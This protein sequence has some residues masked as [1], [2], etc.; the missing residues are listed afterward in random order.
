MP[1]RKGY[2]RTYSRRRRSYARR[3]AGYPASQYGIRY[4]ARDATSYERYGPTKRLASP[5]QQQQRIADAYFGR[6]KYGL[7]RT[8]GSFAKKNNLAQRAFDM[9]VSKLEGAGMYSGQG[10]Y[11]GGAT[12]DLITGGDVSSIPQ[13]ASG[14][15]ETGTLTVQH[16]EYIRDVYGNP[17]GEDFLNQSLSLNPGLEA[18]FPWLSQVAQNFEE[19]EFDQL[20]FTYRSTIADVS[21]ANG[22]V[23]TVMAT[24]NYNANEPAFS[25]KSQMMGYAHTMS[26]KTTNALLHGVECDPNKLSG[27]S[28]KYVRSQGIDP[29]QDIKTYDHGKFQLAIS[30][31]P[32]SIA[33]NTIGELWVSYTVRL[34]KPKY[35]T[36]EGFGISKDIFRNVGGMSTGYDTTVLGLFNGA[37][38]K[39]V[40]NSIG[41]SV[42]SEELQTVITFPS[43]YA[44]N[45]EITFR[46]RSLNQSFDVS[47][48]PNPIGVT[49]AGNVALVSDI[50]AVYPSSTTVPG[51]GSHMSV[52]DND[53]VMCTVHV[54]VDIASNATDN[55]L[56]LLLSHTYP[57]VELNPN[58]SGCALEIQEY[59]ATFGTNTD[60]TPLYQ[61][62]MGNLVSF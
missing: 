5:A 47:V 3:P 31:T 28:G 53:T 44:G 8:F 9:G 48:E 24:T 38:L 30:N 19:Y 7:R 56:T 20:I 57:G 10:S 23:G 22:Q 27:N 6:G 60:P 45:L 12:N 35:Y 41:C 29:H 21:S 39:G 11:E 54:R 14:S 2:R 55:T 52:I 13:F 62:A 43:H 59:N 42:S 40:H 51:V 32:S 1:A 37:P 49:P 33:D 15:D 50:V 17:A 58:T 36:K 25:N 46:M 26:E 4:Q 34:R 16:R 61:D 18:T